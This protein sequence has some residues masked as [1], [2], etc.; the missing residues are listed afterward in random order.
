MSDK[1]LAAIAAGC[2][3]DITIGT[4]IKYREILER[5]I[6]RC[7]GIGVSSSGS[8]ATA[9]FDV[10]ED[11]DELSKDIGRVSMGLGSKYESEPMSDEESA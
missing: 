5:M 11:L 1:P 8:P 4:L 3:A 10:V 2:P 6:G 7:E 9:V